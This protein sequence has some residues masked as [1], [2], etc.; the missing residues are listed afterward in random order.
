[1]NQPSLRLR[2]TVWYTVALLVTL[3]LGAAVILRAQAGV[4]LRRVDRELDDLS[5]TLTSVLGDEL[6]ETPD[7][8]GAA[9]RRARR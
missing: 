2:L 4:G 9:G 1:M 8:A 5:G 3:C 6:G 7:V